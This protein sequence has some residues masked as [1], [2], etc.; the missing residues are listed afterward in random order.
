MPVS[1]VKGD[2]INAKEQ[3][4]VC[5]ANCV[6]TVI[7]NVEEPILAKIVDK[8]PYANIYTNR[9]L[10]DKK[11]SPI[12]TIDIMI[13][14]KK[15]QNI[16]I[17]YSHYYRGIKNFPN[18]SK[19][20]RI[21]WFEK[22]LNKIGNIPGLTS[23]AFQSQF[24]RE[25]GGDWIQ[26]YNLIMDFDKSLAL[27]G[28]NV[29]IVLYDSPDTP[30]PTETN[31]IPK[32]VPKATATTTTLK[33]VPIIKPVIPEAN[34][35]KYDFKTVNETPYK[36]NDIVKLVVMDK[37]TQLI[38][39]QPSKP[40]ISMEIVHTTS[41]TNSEQND[42]SDI[43]SD[44][45]TNIA[46]DD[47][48]SVKKIVPKKKIIKKITPT[49]VI[50]IQILPAKAAEDIITQDTMTADTTSTIIEHETNNSSNHSDDNVS[51]NENVIEIIEN[52]NETKAND[53]KTDETVKEDITDNVT[54]V[55]QVQDGTTVQ[56]ETEIAELNDEMEPDYE[57]SECN[58]EWKYKLSKLL[59]KIK[60]WEFLIEDEQIMKALNKVDK[61]MESEMK[62]FGE[63]YKILPSQDLVFNV[64]NQVPLDDIK[65]VIIGQDPYYAN[66]NEAMGLSFSVP[67]G[68]K[69]PPSLLNIFKE[70][71][72]DIPT[73]KIP[74]SGN[75]TKWVQQG[76]F[77]LN[78]G[79]TVRHKKSESHLKEW[80]SFT[81]R[82]IELISKNSKHPI[83]FIL[84]GN[85]AQK[86]QNLINLKKDIVLKCVHP[87]PLSVAQGGWFG[88]KHFSKTND[89]L[90]KL[91][92]KPIKWDL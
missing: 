61:L 47:V 31:N 22:C 42:I 81:D 19:K 7:D 12:G 87:S 64:F 13:D 59:G 85:Y 1:F 77:L 20:R 80:A 54:E 41:D 62:T 55:N 75:L 5:C 40:N 8:F 60:G 66:E 26:Y 39:E 10:G 45:A 65:V 86:K 53:K 82:V 70:L 15:T 46:Q 25:F 51:I 34:K 56:V 18:D 73:F 16:I 67:D 74:T 72:S 14:D 30:K 4:I 29:N 3:Y 28:Q 84:W 48:K 79:L 11:K 17:M 33:V 24:T 89:E 35:V 32:I 9:K 91:G 52:K 27:E 90:K 23:L 71:K 63:H 83:V 37:T 6:D 50:D 44:N 49:Q 78:A 68:I 92:L 21:E 2:I 36:I 69:I 38:Q 76:I 58:P 43:S 57:G 88:N